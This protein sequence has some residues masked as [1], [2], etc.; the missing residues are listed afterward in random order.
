MNDSEHDFYVIDKKSK[1]STLVVTR[2]FAILHLNSNFRLKAS[3]DD[4]YAVMDTSE[5]PYNTTYEEIGVDD[6]NGKTID[7]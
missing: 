1:K 6:G 7:L 5:K 2:F 4:Y 3:E